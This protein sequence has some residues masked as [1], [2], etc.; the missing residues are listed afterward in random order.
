MPDVTCAL[1]GVAQ[2]LARQGAIVPIY[3]IHAARAEEALS[4]ERTGS[5]TRS[6]SNG[7]GPPDA[8]RA[9]LQGIARLKPAPQNAYLTTT[10]SWSRSASGR[11]VA[12]A[13]SG[14]PKKPR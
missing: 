6:A 9:G 7:K 3:D 13:R 12:S 11:L 2:A 1:A 8:N 5:T 14:L 10:E 4:R